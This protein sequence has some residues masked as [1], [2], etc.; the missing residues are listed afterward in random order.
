MITELP[1]SS[2]PAQGL[3]MMELTIL[4]IAFSRVGFEEI[5]EP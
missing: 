1:D 4:I 5:K 2:F 3:L